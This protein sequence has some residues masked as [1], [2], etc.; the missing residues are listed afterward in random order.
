MLDGRRHALRI[1][2][3]LAACCISGCGISPL[4][5]PLAAYEH[6]QVYHPSRYPD[7][8]WNP[9]GLA[10][11]DAWFA[12]EDGTRLHGWFVSHPHPRAVVLFAHGNAGNLS[13]RAETLKILNERHGVSILAFDYRGFGRS[14]GTPDEAGLLQD[15]RAAR[16]WLAERTNVNEQDVVLMGRS[17]GGGVVVDLA[18]RDGAR[19]LVLAST[20]TSLPD[21][22]AEHVRWIPARL[23]MQNRFDSLSKIGQYD[24]PLL[25]SHGDADEVIPYAQGRKLFEGAAGPKRFVTIPGGRHNSPQ[26]EEYRAAL[27][28]FIGALP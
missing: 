28:E 18:A 14:E 4:R 10:F 23:L 19:G 24:G 22:A 1:V 21:V 20:F 26:S 12:A 3:L 2:I 25:Q 5:S 17:L 13:D 27:D 7:G 16:K 8:N 15:A 11:E 6:A 9:D